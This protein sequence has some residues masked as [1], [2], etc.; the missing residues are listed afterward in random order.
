MSTEELPPRES[1]EF[2]V[3][4][5][6]AGPSGLSAAIRLKQLNAELNVVV[7]EKGSEVGAH[8]LSGAVI[9]PAGLD[10]LIPDW[11][12]DADCPLKTQVKDDRFYWMTGGGAIKLP[13]FMMPPLM[14][15]HHC[16]I[17]SLGNVCRWLARKAEALG[18]E[19][20]PGFAAAEVLY[21]E[22]GNVKGIATGDMGI[23]R[24][25]KPKDSFTRGMELLGKY[26]LFAEGARGSLTKQLINKFALDA[27][28][29]PPKFGI[30]LKEV[31]QIDPAKHQKGLIQHSFGWPLDLKT[32]G[33]SFLYHYDD[34]LVA[35][36][37]VVHLNYDDP[38][39]SPFDEFQRFKTH[40]SI[41]GTFE[42][43]KRLAY[44]A[45]AITEGGYQSVPKLSFPGGALIGCAAG[46][47]NVPRI[48]GVHNAMGTGMLAA[49]HAAA[50]LAADRA[51]DELVEY[52]NAWR[53]S[54][55][56]KDL[57]L[58]RNVK[59]LWSKFG[60][61]LG[62][63]LGGFDMWCNTLFGASLFGTQSHVKP[64]RATLDSAKGH[65]PRNYP[66]PDGKITFDKLSSVFLSNTNHEEDQPIHLKV[67]DMNLQKTSEHDVYAGPSNRYCPAG[68]YEWIEEGSGPRFQINAQNCVHCKTC[69]VKDP[70]GNITWVP[71]EGGGGPNYEA[72]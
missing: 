57:F 62:V 7:V 9:D 29:E 17:G 10:K 44:G 23:G 70:N 67:T 32:G 58:V 48:K 47:V 43:A 5:V 71:P 2:D 36:G 25:G 18:V 19:I 60:T 45:R 24:D 72:M 38:Y 59:P 50:A 11:R 40:P 68:V 66:K 22:A 14:D 52:E 13:N 34:N 30:G 55:V 6:G 27:K 51:N 8:I 1:M 21:D 65:A 63:A 61:V 64:D 16:Y 31:W 15:N 41:R 69:D 37:F 35:V 20:Y 49:E 33:G 4:I 12:E 3:V 56:G 42:G 46:F 26:T 28:S 54:S 53:S 39:L